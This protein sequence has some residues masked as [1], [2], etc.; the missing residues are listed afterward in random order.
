[1]SFLSQSENSLPMLAA[2]A[3]VPLLLGPGDYRA[4]GLKLPAGAQII[5]V[6]GSSRLLFAV[7]VVVIAL[8]GIA[9]SST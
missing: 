6:R 5:G 8:A 3:R 1:M 9:T 4:A 2:S 7:I